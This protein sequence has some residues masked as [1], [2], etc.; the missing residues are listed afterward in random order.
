MEG[1]ELGEVDVGSGLLADR[2]EIGI[3]IGAFDL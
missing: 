2:G 1:D 3:E